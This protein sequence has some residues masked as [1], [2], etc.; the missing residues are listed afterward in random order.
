[1]ARQSVAQ[2]QRFRKGHPCP[3]CDGHKDMPSG[4]GIRCAG[5]KSRDGVYA[6]CT[7][8]ELAGGIAPGNSDGPA[9]YAHRLEGECNCGQTH[10]HAPATPSGEIRYEIRDVE[11]AH[12]A[13]HI[14]H[15][16]PGGGKGFTWRLPDGTNGLGGRKVTS[17]PLYGSEHFKRG[18]RLYTI[19][20]E[21]E[22]A[23]KTLIDA[24]YMAYGTATGATP[25]PDD[26]ALA[27][28]CFGA[29][30]LWPDNDE[31]GRAH[32]DRIAERLRALEVPAIYRLDWPSAPPKG[33]AADFFA[34][35]GAAAFED[36]EA[37]ELLYERP[38]P[39]K[40]PGARGVGAARLRAT[41]QARPAADDWAS[42]LFDR[43]APTA[44][45]PPP[46]RC[47]TIAD[48]R[49]LPEPAWL[50]GRLL[51]ERSLTGI[52]G[53]TGSFKS[54]IALDWAMC[55]A[56]GEPYQGREIARTGPVLYIAAEGAT[57]IL[58]RVEAWCEERGREA[59]SIPL[60]IIPDAPALPEIGV[61]EKLL[62]DMAA[63]VPGQPVA[64]F[65]DTVAKTFE[66]G[67]EENSNDAMNR[68]VKACERLRDG[69]GAAIVPI[70]HA[71][72]GG[73]HERGGSAY[74]AGLDASYEVKREGEIVTL[75][76]KKQRAAVETG[77][78]HMIRKIVELDGRE[79]NMV[80][81]ATSAATARLDETTA[82]MEDVLKSLQLA[83]YSDWLKGCSAVGL[84]ADKSEDG[85]KG[86]FKRGLNVLLE[87]GR[88]AKIGDARAANYRPA[89]P[90]GASTMLP[91]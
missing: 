90:Q 55:L 63:D 69:A 1:M 88:V 9:T 15:S 5:F 39:A 75:T 47:L 46:R 52:Y 27:A 62:A 37:L 60:F 56:T 4:Q 2:D 72:W 79:P 64:I 38:T 67:S 83:T 82:A 87:A 6:H 26:D 42:T 44:T 80:L 49:S 85:K 77:P 43:P 73:A 34:R 10:G 48:L 36:L 89:A 28:I 13:D 53:E 19:I 57:T 18:T 29:V 59:D 81:N 54:Y 11:G 12:V 40:P 31:A 14:R 51:Q 24:G 58:G 50:I 30:V 74:R 65:I 68:Y 20:T 78:L 84:W 35:R 32:M 45:D 25:T 71:G 33:D 17:L 61:A 7:R 70:H 22:K 76:C 41:V 21:G 66:T 16:K 86:A 3:I 8:E 91:F 23:A